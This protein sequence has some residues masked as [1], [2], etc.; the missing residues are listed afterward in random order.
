MQRGFFSKAISWFAQ[1]E[2]NNA[3]AVSRRSAFPSFLSRVPR[4][5]GNRE[6]C[7]NAPFKVVDR[8]WAH[9]SVNRYPYLEAKYRLRALFLK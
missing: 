4:S 8:N 2:G 3:H 6:L 1:N 5:V 7:E 9:R